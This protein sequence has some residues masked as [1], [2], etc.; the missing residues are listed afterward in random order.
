MLEL[1]KELKPPKCHVVQAVLLKHVKESDS[2]VSQKLSRG[3]Q[4]KR[5]CWVKTIRTNDVLYRQFEI[6][7]ERKWTSAHTAKVRSILFD[8]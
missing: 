8:F 6:N 1:I 5:E 3:S 7:L 2:R 4:M